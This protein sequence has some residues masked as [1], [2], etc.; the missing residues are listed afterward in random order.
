[1]SLLKGGYSCFQK[2][3]IEKFGIPKF[4]D[5]EMKNIE[6]LNDL[7]LEEL[8]VQKYDISQTICQ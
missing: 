4:S 6:S 5:S 8:L 7:E 1:M 3:F 2:N